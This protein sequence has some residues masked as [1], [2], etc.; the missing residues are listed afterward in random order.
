MNKSMNKKA[1]KKA[2]AEIA[3]KG[4]ENTSTRELEQMVI[5]SLKNRTGRPSKYKEDHCIRI[6][7]MGR[8]GKFPIEWASELS[9]PK[10]TLDEW[11]KKYPEFSKAYDLA[12]S[13][14]ERFWYDL[15]RR[16]AETGQG[17]TVMIKYIL[18]AA[19]GLVETKGT[20]VSG[21]NGEPIQVNAAISLL[22]QIQATGK[23]F[24]PKG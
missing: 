17:N 3:A 7:N 5:P 8:D 20:E 19:F 6:I 2:K 24:T 14:C 9:I 22:D 1:Y 16:N 23:G 18:S 4:L 11:K 13:F 10:S 12:K 15:A 21:K